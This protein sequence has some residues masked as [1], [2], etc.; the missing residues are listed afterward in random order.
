MII[1]N[2]NPC[3]KCGFMLGEFSAIRGIKIHGKIICGDCAQKANPEYHAW[4]K[5]IDG[6]V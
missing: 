5:E 2:D 3:V 1:S 4:L 6:K